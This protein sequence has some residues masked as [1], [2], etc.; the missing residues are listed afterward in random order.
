MYVKQDYTGN[1]IF[2]SVL[3][4]SFVMFRLKLEDYAT[5]DVI[6]ALYEIKPSR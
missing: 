3:L 6:F 2:G 1:H 5:N 4:K